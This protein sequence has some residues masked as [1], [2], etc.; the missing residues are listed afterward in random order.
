MK[1]ELD[2]VFFA[3]LTPKE[4]NLMIRYCIG[5][6][7][8]AQCST[9]ELYRPLKQKDLRMAFEEQDRKTLERI[10]EYERHMR[11]YDPKHPSEDL[12]VV[13]DS[14]P[15]KEEFE[16]YCKSMI[17]EEKELLRGSRRCYSV[18]VDYEDISSFWMKFHKSLS[19][20]VTF[21]YSNELHEECNF[22]LNEESREAFLHSSLTAPPAKREDWGIVT[23]GNMELAYED[24]SVYR[25][26]DCILTAISHEEIMLAQLDE[27]DFD[28]IER[29]PGGKR[30]AAKIRASVQDD[31]D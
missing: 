19:P 16:N 11:E 7:T 17:E 30:L 2:D 14:V 12:F 15:T 28:A 27:K 18:S 23:F 29:M 26:D 24:L 9:K 21:G 1:Y 25:G 8:R 3:S 5:V 20:R 31:L 13:F 6:G 10:A 4:R 22:E